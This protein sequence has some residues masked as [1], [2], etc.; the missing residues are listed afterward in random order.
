MD[1]FEKI[2][3]LNNEFEAEQMEEILKKKTSPTGLS[4]YQIPCSAALKFSKTAGAILKLHP[5]LKTRYWRS[6]QTSREN[7]FRLT[8]VP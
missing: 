8:E 2:L 4:R 6:M 3:D 5:D 7:D 1:E